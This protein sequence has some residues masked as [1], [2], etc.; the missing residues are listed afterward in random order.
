MFE[1]KY[2]LLTKIALL[3]YFFHHHEFY[4][5]LRNIFSPIRRHCRHTGS[6][7][8][9]ISLSTSP[10]EFIDFYNYGFEKKI[11]I[12]TGF[13]LNNY[14]KNIIIPN[15]FEPFEKRNIKLKFSYFP[16]NQKMY[17]FKGD[18]DQDRPSILS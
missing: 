5:P 4:S 17:L 7:Y 6:V 10:Y 16:H 2:I 8:L 1:L 13:K 12:N 9:A 11:I 15:Y 3:I 14:T 18:C